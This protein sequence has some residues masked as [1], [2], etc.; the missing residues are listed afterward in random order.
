MLYNIS[1]VEK[2]F[3][4]LMSELEKKRA[5]EKNDEEGLERIV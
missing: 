4:K 3:E 2:T 1:D 5:G